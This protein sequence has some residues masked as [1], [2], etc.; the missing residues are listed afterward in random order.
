VQKALDP[1]V[2]KINFRLAFS[3]CDLSKFESEVIVQID[4]DLRHCQIMTPGGFRRSARDHHLAQPADGA[5]RW[6]FGLSNSRRDRGRA[7]YE[8]D[9]RTA[10]VAHVVQTLAARSPA[11]DA[12]PDLWDTAH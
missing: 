8:I 10:G 4:R 1:L 11:S 5:V 12:A 7:Q 9:L 3:V 6:L 2:D